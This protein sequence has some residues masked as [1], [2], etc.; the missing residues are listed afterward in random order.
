M[1]ESCFEFGG[2]TCCLKPGRFLGLLVAH[3]MASNNL[4]D[5]RVCGPSGPTG[6]SKLTQYCIIV[7]FHE[8]EFKFCFGML[9]CSLAKCLVFR[10]LAQ[11]GTMPKQSRVV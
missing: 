9:P 10:I 8:G 7:T 2:S 5:F 6:T 3:V 4:Q 1:G 11:Y